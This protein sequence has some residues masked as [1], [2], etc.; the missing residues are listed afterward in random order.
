MKYQN[1]PDELK[2]L[3]QWVNALDGSKT[4]MCSF[5]YRPASSTDKTTWSTFSEAEESFQHGMYDYCGF[6]FADNGYVGIDIDTGFDEDGFLT[7]ECASIISLCQSYTEVSKSGRGVHI[8]LKGDLPFNGKNNLH[9][10]EIYKAYR[11]FIFTGNVIL[12][13][14]IVENQQA[15]DKI[16]DKYFMSDAPE[17]KTSKHAGIQKIYRP[18]WSHP[19]TSSGRLKLHPDYPAILPG[20]RN[21]SLA[22]L[23][24]SMHTIGYGRDQILEELMK[25]NQTACKPPLSRSEVESICASITKYSR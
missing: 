12:Y 8:V 15:I 16:V 21:L 3:K 7:E 18:D 14:S 11:Y 9:G 24:G 25:V 1:V 17:Q 22:S 6:V 10:V 13:H 2:N 5:E 23:A 20:G 19:L 4:P